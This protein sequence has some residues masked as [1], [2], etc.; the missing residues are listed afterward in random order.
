EQ[1]VAELVA[2]GQRGHGARAADLEQAL[3]RRVRRRRAALDLERGAERTGHAQAL[4][5][6][7]AQAPAISPAVARVEHAAEIP[8]P[9]PEA[10]AAEG[11]RV[12]VVLRGRIEGNI[13]TVAEEAELGLHV[14]GLVERMTEAGLEAEIGGP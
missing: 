14:H 7:G 9:T 4:A 10:D 13:V 6:R 2:V 3:A 11:F 12:F 8:V 1:V 5:E